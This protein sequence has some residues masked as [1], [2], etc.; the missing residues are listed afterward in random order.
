MVGAFERFDRA[1]LYV[2]GA[3]MWNG[4]VPWVLKRYLD[5]ITQPGLLFRFAP[6]SGYRGLLRRKH[7][8]LAATSSVYRPGVD[9]AFGADFHSTYLRY[10][11]QFAG[12]DSV[13]EIGM[14]PVSR[15]DP[16]FPARLDD[17]LQTARALAHSV[18]PPVE[19]GSRL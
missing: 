4:G 6:D 13:D 15:H 2:I 11:L 14:Q 10:W 19:R 3:P 7:A 1:D 5:T 16:G 18:L 17:A 12:I 9:V 8:V